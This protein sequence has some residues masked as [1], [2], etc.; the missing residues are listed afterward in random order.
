MKLPRIV[1]HKHLG[2]T[3]RIPIV[4]NA[5][6]L[7]SH[8]GFWSYG[9]LQTFHHGEVTR[10]IEAY[11]KPEDHFRINTDHPRE[12]GTAN[13]KHHDRIDNEEVGD[14]VITLNSFQRP[15]RTGTLKHRAVLLVGDFL[16]VPS[17][18]HLVVVKLT[19]CIV[20][21]TFARLRKLIVVVSEPVSIIDLD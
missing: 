5:R 8:V 2:N 14:R 21:A 6:V 11:I 18:D 20:D 15:G 17:L 10:R 16:S 7:V 1:N 9:V 4:S 12:K 13:R 3:V 19:H